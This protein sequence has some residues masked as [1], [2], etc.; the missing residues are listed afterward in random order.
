VRSDLDACVKSPRILHLLSNYRW[1]ERAEPAANLALAQKRAGRRVAFACGSPPRVRPN[2]VALELEQRGLAPLVWEMPKHFALGPMLR[3]AA[4]MREML[5]RNDV[6]VIHCHLPNAHLTA[7]IALRTVTQRPLIVRS[8]YEPEGLPRSLRESYV[9]HRATD[10]LIVTTDE[11]REKMGAQHAQLRDRTAII[12]PGI[13]LDRFAPDRAIAE[14]PAIAGLPDDAFVVGVVSRL[15]KDR[16]VDIVID[17]VAQLAA[18]CPKLHLLIIGRGGPQELEEAVSRPLARAGCANRV[19]LAGYLR[20]DALVAGYRRMNALAYPA[21]GTDKSCRTVREAMA[22]GV[23]V[24][25]VR[26]GYVPHL[27]EDG[28]TGLLADQSAQSFARAIQALYGD[29]AL[30]KRLAEESLSRSRERFSLD[31]Q[32]A[33]TLEFYATLR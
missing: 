25:G 8:V 2:R 4:R 29:A 26:V 6:D 19:H 17:A 18:D 15:R 20:D 23:P 30:R 22:A 14:L 9:L 16:R 21:P 11:A 7:A 12:E 31:A 10:G 1:T 13:D 24:V 28:G 33:R 27:I 3:D 5:A 32:A